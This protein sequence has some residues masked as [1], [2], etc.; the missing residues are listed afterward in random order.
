MNKVC[1]M[2]LTGCK[3]CSA[4]DTCTLC[5]TGLTNDG[6]GT[7][8]YSNNNT[9][10]CSNGYYANTLDNCSQCYP[11]CQTCLGGKVSDCLTCFLG[12]SFNNGIC[13]ANCNSD[14]YYNNNT[15]S[16]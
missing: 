13:T 1:T 3:T 2:C 10:N 8:S 9:V 6:N 5:N 16:C 14:S 12:S 15:S 11:T 4:I 7:C